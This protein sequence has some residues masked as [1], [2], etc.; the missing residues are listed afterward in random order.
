M[1]IGININKALEKLLNYFKRKED[2]SA[3]KDIEDFSSLG[4][5]KGTVRLTFIEDTAGGKWSAAS[6][7]KRLSENGLFNWVYKPDTKVNSEG[8]AYFEFS[9]DFNKI[10]EVLKN[11]GYWGRHQILVYRKN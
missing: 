5:G 8:Y 10:E 11:H 6:V 1:G 3:L 9:G 2:H 7:K 4:D